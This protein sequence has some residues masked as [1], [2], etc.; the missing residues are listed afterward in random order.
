MV[1]S[2]KSFPS[3][4]RET[5]V[6]LGNDFPKFG[7]LVS[8]VS[9][10]HVGCG[11]RLYPDCVN[12]DAGPLIG[13]DGELSTPGDL[14]ALPGGAY[15]LQADLTQG[16]PFAA[17]TF[18]WIIAEHI[19]EHLTFSDATLWLTEMRRLLH[20]A[21]TLR[22]STPDLAKYAE[23]YRDPKRTFF[24]EH[25]ENIKVHSSSPF[26]KRRAWL[27]NQIF[28]LW[29]HKWIY[30]FE[31]IAYAAGL[32]GFSAE[33]ITTCSF[34]VGRIKAVAE[35]DWDLRRDESLYV[36]LTKGTSQFSLS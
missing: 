13:F 14:V 32:A 1:E 30:D 5:V 23:G 33:E 12:V 35:L 4:T 7:K 31:E 29:G 16:L 6:N 22:I 9:G 34:G 18:Q 19:I 17:D 27:L 3:L 26:P 15:Y 25:W 21:G 24:D 11:S 10:L 20:P 8:S 2:E 36:E 28:Y